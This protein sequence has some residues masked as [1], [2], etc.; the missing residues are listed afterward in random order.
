MNW[1]VPKATWRGFLQGALALTIA[2]SGCALL[3]PAAG[4]APS[5]RAKNSSRHQPGKGERAAQAVAGNEA[6]RRCVKRRSKAAPRKRTCRRTRQRAET[7]ASNRRSGQRAAPEAPAPAGDLP[8][9]ANAVDPVDPPMPLPLEKPED[10]SEPPLGPEDPESSPPPPPESEEPPAV[11]PRCELVEGDCSIYS[12]KFWELLA[13]YE[14]F[15]I[16]PGVY[17]YPPSC[18]EAWEANEP[19]FCIAALAF[20]YPDGTIGIGHWVVDPCAPNGWSLMGPEP[21]CSPS[22]E[23]AEAS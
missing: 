17:P 14:R 5:D 1:G 15:E 16:A 18:M 6:R 9:P 7:K 4:A 20:L 11:T 12:D 23:S 21:P 22:E 2:V 3:P 19:I 10:E 13:K 8:L